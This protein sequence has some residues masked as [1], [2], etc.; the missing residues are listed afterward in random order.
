MLWQLTRRIRQWWKPIILWNIHW[1][2]HTIHSKLNKTWGMCCTMHAKDEGSKVHL[3][4]LFFLFVACPLA[5]KVTNYSWSL[6]QPSCCF[7]ADVPQVSPALEPLYICQSPEL[8]AWLQPESSSPVFSHPPPPEFEITL[9]PLLIRIR[10]WW[11]L[12]SLCLSFLTC[13]RG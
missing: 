5:V 9:V 3:I 13:E 8:Q 6:F 1:G 11:G 4:D 10:P 2:L 12:N 7:C